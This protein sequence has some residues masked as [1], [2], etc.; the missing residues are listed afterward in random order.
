MRIIV[1]TGLALLAFAANSVLCRLALGTEQA[2]AAG[3]TAI[4]LGAGALVLMLLVRL[5]TAKTV[6]RGGDWLSALMLFAYAAAFS[7][8]YISLETGTGAL[9][10]FGVVQL[11]MMLSGLFSGHRPS[12]LEWLGVVIAFSGLVYLVSPGLQAPPLGGALLM[13]LAGVA[14]GVYSL[15]GR[16]SRQPL[17][18][19]A[20]NFL[21]S[22]PMAAVLLLLFYQDLQVTWYGGLLAVLSGALASGVGYAVW[23]AVLPK[24]KPSQASVLQLLVPVIAALGGV[25]A[26]AE[27]PGMRLLVASI[28]VLGGV[29]LVL[30]VNAVRQR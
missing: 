7:F 16:G 22:V 30:W 20:G 17:G 11:T 2:D 26:M 14:W 1:L 3:F 21:L 5:S 24:L 15:R 6:E 9:I 12:A 23:Y 18:D 13:A 19:T 10:L 27:V 25:V 4:R 28:A 29:A 8:A